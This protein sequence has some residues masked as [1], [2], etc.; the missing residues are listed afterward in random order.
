MADWTRGEHTRA[1][2]GRGADLGPSRCLPPSVE[3]L[4]AG[5][6]K[7]GL[8]GGAGSDC[9]PCCPQGRKLEV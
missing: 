8:S 9:G 7:P 5:T 2:R 3:G 4:Q 6:W 1:G